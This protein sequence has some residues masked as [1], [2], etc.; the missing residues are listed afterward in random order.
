ME[1][2]WDDCV[3]FFC[4]QLIQYRVAGST[5]IKNKIT[6]LRWTVWILEVDEEGGIKNRLMALQNSVFSIMTGYEFFFQTK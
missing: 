4:Y 3:L 1:N 6:R 2:L 5:R